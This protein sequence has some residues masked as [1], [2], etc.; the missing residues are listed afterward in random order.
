M[1]G[2]PEIAD[3]RRL[4]HEMRGEGDGLM[5]M[6]PKVQ[7]VAFAMERQARRRPIQTEP[8]TPS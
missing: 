2:L 5:A 6:E 3:E 4:S 1:D 8:R 7:I